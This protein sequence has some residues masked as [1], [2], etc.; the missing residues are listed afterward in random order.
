MKGPVFVLFAAEIIRQSNFIDNHTM[1]LCCVKMGE[2]T[3][4]KYVKDN[5]LGKQSFLRP[6][7]L[8]RPRIR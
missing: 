4:Q 1:R 3:S 5:G 8:A 2:I 7:H 6:V